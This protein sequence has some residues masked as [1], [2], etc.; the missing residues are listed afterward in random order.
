MAICYRTKIKNK[1][2][3]RSNGSIRLTDENK[4]IVIHDKLSQS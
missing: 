1:S 2:R 4:C 3:F